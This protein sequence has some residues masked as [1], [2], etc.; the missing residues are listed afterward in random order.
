MGSSGTEFTA[1]FADVPL[2]TRLLVSGEDRWDEGAMK[3]PIVWS[4]GF[5]RYY[6]RETAAAWRDAVSR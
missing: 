1:D 5:T 4:C 3:H 6:D 2:G